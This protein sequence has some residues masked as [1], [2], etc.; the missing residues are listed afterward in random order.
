MR[1]RGLI[2]RILARDP[3]FRGLM[4]FTLAETLW[5]YDHGHRDLLLAYPTT[6]RSDLAR[7]GDLDGEGRPILMVDSDRAPQFHRGR[8][9]IPGGPRPVVHRARHGVPR[10]RRPGEDRP[11]ALSGPHPRGSRRPRTPDRGPAR[12]RARGADGIRGPHRRRRRPAARQAAPGFRDPPDAASVGV[13]DRRSAGRRRG[14]RAGGRPGRD[15]ERR[16]DR[17]PAVDDARG[18]R[19]RA[20][21][22]VGLLRADPVRPL[23]RVHASPGRGVRAAR[24]APRGTRG[25]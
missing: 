8:E 2:D 7:L 22:G 12:V 24:G 21:R 5:L 19:H 14:R 6:S 17:Q 23:L 3:R 15:R 1:C 9:S 4:T 13:G 10:R 11:Q 25:P 20:D 16:R 18:R